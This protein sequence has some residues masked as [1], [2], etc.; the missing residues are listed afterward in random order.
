[1][2]TQ[3]IHFLNFVISRS[4]RLKRM[5]ERIYIEMNSR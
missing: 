3:N 4:V 2:Q 1:M 5:N